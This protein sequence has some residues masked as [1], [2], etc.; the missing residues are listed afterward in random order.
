MKQF[1]QENKGSISILATLSIVSVLMILFLSI[2]IGNIYAKKNLVED[3][4]D[5]IGPALLQQQIKRYLDDTVTIIESQDADWLAQTMLDDLIPAGQSN[6]LKDATYIITFGV[7]NDTDI[8]NS[9]TAGFHPFGTTASLNVTIPNTDAT[10][11]TTDPHLDNVTLVNGQDLAVAFQLFYNTSPL[12]D[13][14]SFGESGIITL[15]GKG[16][17]QTDLQPIIDEKP[18]GEESDCC[19]NKAG[20]LNN[21][22]VKY[23]LTF[24]PPFFVCK[25]ADGGMFFGQPTYDMCYKDDPQICEDY[26]DCQGHFFEN[27]FSGQLFSKFFKML[28][29]WFDNFMERLLNSIKKVDQAVEDA[30]DGWA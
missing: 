14:L 23:S 12:G 10:D 28:S 8:N 13:M 17:W 15:K 22:D 26:F 21:I 4:A 25:Y 19:C 1:W 3:T 9:L 7:I 27:L 5:A 29:C 30:W 16:M 11:L 24:I 20:E 6:P 2:N 18:T